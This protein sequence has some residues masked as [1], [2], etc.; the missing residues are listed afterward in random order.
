MSVTPNRD[1]VC[2]IAVEDDILS[3]FLFPKQ[4]LYMIKQL[5]TLCKNFLGKNFFP[6]QQHINRSVIHKNNSSF[7]KTQEHAFDNSI[8]VYCII[9]LWHNVFCI[10]HGNFLY[11]S[12]L[13]FAW[14]YFVFCSWPALIF[15]QLVSFVWGSDENVFIGI[16]LKKNS[17]SYSK[18]LFIKPTFIKF[19]FSL[20][21]LQIFMSDLNVSV[22]EY[23]RNC[24]AVFS[25]L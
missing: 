3:F 25:L 22:C 13:Y 19:S 10:L 18:S 5:W 2:S 20:S 17:A 12:I 6:P 23:I 4:H 8:S 7:Q 11:F 9:Y 16:K 15:F 24:T 14:E 1:W 21:M